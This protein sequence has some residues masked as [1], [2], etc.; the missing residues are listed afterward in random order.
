MIKFSS[1]PTLPTT[2]D[3]GLALESRRA[4]VEYEDRLLCLRPLQANRTDR[5][6]L[7]SLRSSTLREVLPP[8]SIKLESR[9]LLLHKPEVGADLDG[10]AGEEASGGGGEGLG[11]G[12]GR[13]HWL[14]LRFWA[15][16]FF[17]KDCV[18]KERDRCGVRDRDRDEKEWAPNYAAYHPFGVDVHLS[19][20]IV[21]HIAR[22]VELPAVNSS[23]N[24]P[25][26]LIVNTQIP[27]YPASLFQSETDGEGM[28]IVLYFKLNESYSKEL[29]PI[30]KKNIRIPIYGVLMLLIFSSINDAMENIS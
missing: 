27:L 18:L 1:V 30:F 29:P 23:G 12:V 7:Q 9:K 3:D 15:V 4:A 14:G 8:A 21:D 28:N 24:L 13:R 22:F 11:G 2:R 26:I 19:P 17:F 16:R 25:H 20:R 10:L 5:S 6:L